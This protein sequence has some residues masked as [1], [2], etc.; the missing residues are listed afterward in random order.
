MVQPKDTREI[1]CKTS[2]NWRFFDQINIQPYNLNKQSKKTNYKITYTH[3]QIHVYTIFV[4]ILD[5]IH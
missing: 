2:M 3:T 5:K 4:N 1:I